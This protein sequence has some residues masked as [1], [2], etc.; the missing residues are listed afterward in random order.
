VRE[1]EVMALSAA[2]SVLMPFDMPSRSEER[3]LPRRLRLAAVKKLVGLSRAELTFLPVARRSWT[4]DW[5]SAVLWRVR[6]LARIALER[7]MLLAMVET[8]SGR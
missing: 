4:R 7:T 5:R 3:S 8:L 1:I 2:S 6:R